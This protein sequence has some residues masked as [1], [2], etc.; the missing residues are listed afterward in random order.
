MTTHRLTYALAEGSVL[1]RGILDSPAPA[2]I[3]TG[4]GWRT[5]HAPLETIA[6]RFGFRQISDDEAER[7]LSAHEVRID[8]GDIA[9]SWHPGRER[10]TTRPL[11][12]VTDSS[13]T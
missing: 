6:R 1:V 12:P 10:S 2:S 13:S 7:L 4:W 3:W 11:A 9:V 8:L 5:L